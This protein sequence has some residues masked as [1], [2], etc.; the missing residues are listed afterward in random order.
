[1]RLSSLDFLK[2]CPIIHLSIATNE[3]I[4]TFFNNQYSCLTL[5]L[6]FCFVMMYSLSAMEDKQSQSNLVGN[7][8]VLDEKTII[9]AS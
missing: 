2:G 9:I 1:M 6:V 3:I 4:K 8:L 5:P 7:H